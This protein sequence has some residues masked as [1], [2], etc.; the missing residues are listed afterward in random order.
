MKRAEIIERANARKNQQ[1][2]TN[3]AAL[4]VFNRAM[5]EYMKAARVKTSRLRSCSAAVVETE[6]YYLLLSYRKWI[7]AISKKT[8]VG[9]DVLRHEYGYTSTSAQHLSK[10]FRDNGVDWRNVKTWR[11]HA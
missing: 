4:N 11:V 10:F 2:N 8:G 5:S 9:V 3:R 1:R 6:N 7:G